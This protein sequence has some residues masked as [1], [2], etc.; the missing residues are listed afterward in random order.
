MHL[1]VRAARN[2]RINPTTTTPPAVAAALSNSGTTSLG[3]PAQIFRRCFSLP[4]PTTP[5]SAVLHSSSARLASAL[6]S[7]SS[8]SLSSSSAAGSSLGVAARGFLPSF[9]TSSAANSPLAATAAAAAAAATAAAT[10]ARCGSTA[11]AV[12]ARAV[13]G[14]PLG[15]TMRA[16]AG[17]LPSGAAAAA[18]AAVSARAT[19]AALA[20]VTTKA[21]T[22]APFARSA[23]GL[24][25]VARS[26]LSLM[27]AGLTALAATQLL[28]GATVHASE[29]PSYSPGLLHVPP[30]AAHAASATASAARLESTNPAADSSAAV[31]ASWWWQKATADGQS[32]AASQIPSPT[33][34]HVHSP[35]AYRSSHAYSVRRSHSHT[36]TPSASHGASPPPR[37]GLLSAGGHGS[38]FLDSGS[39]LTSWARAS[40]L[41]RSSSCLPPLSAPTDL[42]PSASAAAAARRACSPPGAAHSALLSPPPAPFRPAQEALRPRS[43]PPLMAQSAWDWQLC[44]ATSELTREAGPNQAM[45]GSQ[46]EKEWVETSDVGERHVRVPLWNEEQQQPQQQQQQEIEGNK[47]AEQYPHGQ[48]HGHAYELLSSPAEAAAVAEALCHSQ[49]RAREAEQAAAEAE[50]RQQWL[51]QLFWHECTRSYSFHQWAHMLQLQVERDQLLMLIGAEAAAAGAAA[52]AGAGASGPGISDMSVRGVC[53][54]HGADDGG[55]GGCASGPSAARGDATAG[56]RMEDF[57]LSGQTAAVAAAREG[58]VIY[59]KTGRYEEQVRVTVRRLTLLGDGPSRTILSFN[60]SQAGDGASLTD[61]PVLGVQMSG[62]VAMG[63]AVE[64]TAGVAGNQAV[65]LLVNADR[66]AFY[67]C[68]FSG[69]QDTVFAWGKRQYFHNCTIEGSVDFIFGYASA[70]FDRCRL[71]VRKGRNQSYIAASGRALANDTGGFVFIDSRVETAGATQIALARPW[72]MCA[73]TIYIRTYLDTNIMNEGWE[74]WHNRINSRTPYFAETRAFVLSPPYTLRVATMTTV[75][76]ELFQ[77]KERNPLVLLGAFTT[78]AVLVAGLA[79]FKQ[80]ND[81]RSQMLMRARVVAQGGTVALML[82]TIGLGEF[83][84]RM[85]NF[86]QK[87]LSPASKEK[88]SS[89]P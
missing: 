56:D 33:A 34:S 51:E 77:Q 25:H 42:P 36:V 37:A 62:F 53:G 41:S 1:I 61:S 18:T 15:V 28:P 71:R 54:S 20:R 22:A 65:A 19:A 44:S 45:L 40:H 82:G 47:R 10:V 76:A 64:N 49:S 79:S 84:E 24:L 4:D 9:Q 30:T 55:G 80:G 5:C 3:I 81:K 89:Q 87:F 2:S 48:G 69:Y 73:R 50:S 63:I 29:R 13:G 12:G 11:A 88:P 31:S 60:R 68:R 72:G 26:V 85:H 59:I 57:F 43:P 66:S 67:Q 86:S 74:A 27:G 17:S 46:G 38:L 83:Q 6:P 32:R 75:D 35:L 23:A 52:G 70:V 39:S 21:A 16:P 7:S 58:A 8:S 14:L 78:A